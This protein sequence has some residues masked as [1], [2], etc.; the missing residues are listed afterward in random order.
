MKMPWLSLATGLAVFAAAGSAA[1]AGAGWVEPIKSGLGAFRDTG[2]WALVGDV[3]KDP[4]QGTRLAAREGAG[5]IYN[6]KDGRT[7]DL[8]TREEFGDVE[9]YVEFMV[10][11]KSNSGVYLQGRYEIQVFDSYGNPHPAHSDC[12]GIYERWENDRGFE[13]HAPRVNAAKPAG[14]WQAFDIIFHAPRFDAAG[15]KI[16]N[17]KFEK[18]VLNGQV[19]HTNVEVTGPTRA[20]RFND[21]KPEGPLMAQ[22]DHGP[23][24]YR[25]IRIRSLAG[26]AARALF[27]M[28]TYTQRP[29]PRGAMPVSQQMDLLK[30]LGYA[31]VAWTADDPARVKSARELAE[32]R[33]LKMVAIYCQATLTRDGLQGEARLPGIIAAL[34]GSGCI[35]WLHI[36]SS[37]FATSA[38]EGDATALAGLREIA[39]WAEQAGLSVAIYPHLGEWAERVQDAV[40]VANQVDRKN[41]GVTFNLCHCLKA[42]DEEQIPALLALAA[43]RLLLVTING[44]DRGAASAGWDR[45]I[46]TLD[47]GSFDLKPVL[48]KLKELDYAGPIACQGYGI[49]G[50]IRDNLTRTMGAWKKMW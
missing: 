21:E 36:G 13:G 12:G 37:D 47:R 3:A 9:V 39:G 31:G 48:R 46:Q 40:R 22:G 49:P 27:A 43:P 34:K 10:P 17:A 5:V 4:Q 23:V 26:A 15:R 18:V 6:G 7:V 19:V 32:A 35:I 11:D 1:W 20:A 33:G 8:L 38:P 28:D 45:L 50:D 24:A 2:E 44:A 30:E 25:N 14:E 42:G 16:T 29:Y 41:F